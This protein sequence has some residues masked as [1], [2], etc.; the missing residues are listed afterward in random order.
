MTAVEKEFRLK[1]QFMNPITQ[2]LGQ[3]VSSERVRDLWV[4]ALEMKNEACDKSEELQVL[5]ENV[6]LDNLDALIDEAWHDI[7]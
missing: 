6:A 3:A 2:K 1:E 5:R 7:L 4:S